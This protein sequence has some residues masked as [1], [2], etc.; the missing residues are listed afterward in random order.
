MS[1]KKEIYLERDKQLRMEDLY[2]ANPKHINKIIYKK[3][4]VQESFS[5]KKIDI[6]DKNTLESL[7]NEINIIIFTATEVEKRTALEFMNSLIDRDSVL[8]G[9]V[10]NE[11]Y[12]VGRLGLYNVVLTMCKPGSVRSALSSND[13][14]HFW[15]L[16][17]AILCGICFGLNKKQQKIGDVL[18][19][20]QVVSYEVERVGKKKVPRGIPIPS[21][22]I[23]I[24]RF[25]NETK[26]NFFIPRRNFFFLR[27]RYKAKK[28]YGQILSGEKLVDDKKFRKNLIKKYPNAKGGDMEGAGIGRSAFNK[29]IDWILIK[30]ISDWAYKKNKKYQKVA[31]ESAIGLVKCVLSNPNALE[32]LN[33]S[34]Y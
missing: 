21:S 4:K 13:A 14:F 6:V 17:I 2:D 8:E 18:I 9:Y 20:E 11:T 34:P 30:G 15:S 12:Y 31:A 32:E 1:S 28:I 10:E 16:K 27:K 5:K 29:K 19:S 26:W 33:I 25:K 23:L 7:K 3:I 22:P 24:N